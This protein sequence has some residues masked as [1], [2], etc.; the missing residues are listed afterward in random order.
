[1]P[2]GSC[3][4]GRSPP[5]GVPRPHRRNAPHAGGRRDGRPRAA[6][7]PSRCSRILELGTDCAVPVH[8]GPLRSCRK[9]GASGSRRRR[10]AQMRRGSRARSGCR[11]AGPSPSRIGMPP[12]TCTCSYRLEAL[13]AVRSRAERPLVP[14]Q[15][16]LQRA[17]RVQSGRAPD[18]APSALPQRAGDRVSAPGD[19]IYILRDV[20]SRAHDGR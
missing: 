6:S 10:T 16:A 15:P 11:R 14:E 7:R 20:A 1:V 3:G 4:A 17:A 12:T 5:C 2:E 13:H 18:H 19:G 8:D 9:R